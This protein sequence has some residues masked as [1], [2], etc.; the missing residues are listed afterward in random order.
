MG[1][2]L[3]LLS[4]QGLL[5]YTSSQEH[6][7]MHVWLHLAVRFYSVGSDLSC[8]WDYSLLICFC[9]ACA[10]LFGAPLV[11]TGNEAMKHSI[12]TRLPG[13]SHMPEVCV[14]V[15]G[16]GWVEGEKVLASPKLYDLR[17]SAP[18]IT[19]AL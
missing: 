9:P 12:F 8:Q 1:P 19:M 14:C 10:W 2:H 4:L 15:W 6:P 16:G 11:W 7:W 5:D 3:G 17:M 18:I 13:G